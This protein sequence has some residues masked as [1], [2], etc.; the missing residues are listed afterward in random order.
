M[1]QQ[2]QPAHMMS[3]QLQAGWT[4]RIELAQP[5]YRSGALTS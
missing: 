4:T 2:P 1:L 5:D 3:L